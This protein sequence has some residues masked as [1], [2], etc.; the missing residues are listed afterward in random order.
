M[1][2]YAVVFFIFGYIAAGLAAVS[3]EIFPQGWAGELGIRESVQGLV[4]SQSGGSIL[5]KT[6][7]GDRTEIGFSIDKIFDFF[8][9][10]DEKLPS[11]LVFL[12][13]GK[14]LGI[15]RSQAGTA[16]FLCV[17]IGLLVLFWLKR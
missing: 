13:P 2:R 15:F 1:F 16:R 8:E 3:L 7:P 6:Q 4:Q 14:V 5:E 17:F 11:F 9:G 12:N 10:F